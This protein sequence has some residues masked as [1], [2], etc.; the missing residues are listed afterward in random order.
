MN[1]FHLAIFLTLMVA[2]GSVQAEEGIGGR[3]AGSAE[4]AAR[5]ALGEA[6][7]ESRVTRG[8]KSESVGILA[9][10]PAGSGD[11][12]AA[13][14]KGGD[15]KTLTLMA[16]GETGKR[17]ANLAKRGAQVKVTGEANG[18]IMT[19]SAVQVTSAEGDKPEKKKKKKND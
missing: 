9:E 11:D 10:K 8:V 14:L 18:D 1:K 17:L 19:V 7:S 12:I 13:L 15:G 2:F 4:N 16:R 5:K 3:A 6:K